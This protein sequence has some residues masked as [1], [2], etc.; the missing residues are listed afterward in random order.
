MPN[1]GT[2]LERGAKTRKNL[3]FQERQ[4]MLYRDRSA[5]E[6]KNPK[7]QGLSH[8]S[9]GRRYEKKDAPEGFE[10]YAGRG[11]STK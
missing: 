7:K 10:D 11:G 1:D 9:M 2:G 5:R 8:I 6:K 3:L 4:K